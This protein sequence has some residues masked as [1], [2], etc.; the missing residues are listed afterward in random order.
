M[1]TTLLELIEQLKDKAKKAGLGYDPSV[2]EKIAKV[3]IK[4]GIPLSQCPC[5]SV[6]CANLA[7]ARKDP[8]RGC[9]SLKCHKEIA[10]TGK[11]HCGVFIK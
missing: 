1:E 4:L 8:F 2:I 6:S 10:E 11:C 9:I 3:R 7:G 5:A